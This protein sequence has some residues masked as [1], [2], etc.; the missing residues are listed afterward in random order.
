MYGCETWTL[1]KAEVDKLEAFEM[2]LWRKEEKLSW[3]DKVSK[4]EVLKR[5]EETRCSTKAVYERK[6]NW[7]GHVLRGN[8]M[9]I[10]ALEGRMMGKRGRGRPRIGMLDELMEG[11]FEK[12]EE[13]G[14]NE[15]GVEEVCAK[16]LP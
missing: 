12:N 6:K 9:L 4:E 10:D 3:K 2:W 11:S 7:I 8:D 14:G 13:K 1:R 5:V 15:G 16:D